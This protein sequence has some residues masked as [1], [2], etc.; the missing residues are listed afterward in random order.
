MTFF[1]KRFPE[2]N[3]LKENK[4]KAQYWK[5][6]SQIKLNDTAVDTGIKGWKQ[7]KTEDDADYEASFMK[8]SIGH[9]WSKYS[10]IGDIFSYRDHNNIPKVTILVKNNEI[11]HAREERNIRLSKENIKSLHEFAKQMNF[12]VSLEPYEFDFFL[13]DNDINTKIVYLLRKDNKNHIHSII[14]EGQLNE[15]DMQTIHNNLQNG[16]NFLP[17]DLNIPSISG[18]NEEH[19]ILLIEN[20]MENPEMELFHNILTATSFMNYFPHGNL[21]KTI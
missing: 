12:K 20:T 5:Y 9:S 18:K 19:E 2:N 6:L 1:K 10:N 14:L 8:H 17:K 16:K 21:M 4:R 3:E 15:Y 13:N 11:I 7:L